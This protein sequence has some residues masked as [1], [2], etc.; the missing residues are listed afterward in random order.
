M[1]NTPF[2]SAFT[3]VYVFLLNIFLLTK[4]FLQC[5]RRYSLIVDKWC[6]FLEN[7]GLFQYPW[8]LPQYGSIVFFLDFSNNY[9]RVMRCLLS[10]FAIKTLG[11]FVELVNII[12]LVETSRAQNQYFIRHP[13]RSSIQAKLQWERILQS[14]SLTVREGNNVGNFLGC[15]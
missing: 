14:W 11:L 15:W 5:L 10:S 2:P 3:P 13:F 7:L 6:F 1:P 12:I 4:T 8:P 9:S